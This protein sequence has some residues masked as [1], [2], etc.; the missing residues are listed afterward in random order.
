MKK[1][2]Y[3]VTWTTGHEDFIYAIE[4]RDL[5]DYCRSVGRHNHMKTIEKVKKLPPA[6]KERML[7]HVKIRLK[8]ARSELRA[9]MKG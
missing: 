8:H 7:Q 6:V 9:I 1:F 2:W 3:R 4:I 5:A